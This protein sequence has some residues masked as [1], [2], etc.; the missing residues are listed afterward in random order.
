M[1]ERAGSQYQ[2]HKSE[3]P[4]LYADIEAKQGG[5][6]QAVFKRPNPANALAKPMP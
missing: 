4:D 2:Q 1:R 3:L 5:W 6:Q